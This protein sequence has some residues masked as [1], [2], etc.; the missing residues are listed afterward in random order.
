MD[1]HGGDGDD[2]EAAMFSSAVEEEDDGAVAL[3]LLCPVREVEEGDGV[4]VVLPVRSAWTEKLHGVVASSTSCFCSLRFREE[5]GG[6]GREKKQRRRR[7][8]EEEP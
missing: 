1:G 3:L 5:K 6:R 7:G 2:E 4:E 8:K